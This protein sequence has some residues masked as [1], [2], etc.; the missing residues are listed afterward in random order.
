MDIELV[1]PRKF[2]KNII[3]EKMYKRISIDYPILVRPEVA[4]KLS[5][6]ADKLP[7]PYKLRIDDGYRALY[8][9]NILWQN[10]WNQFQKENPSLNKKELY[11]RTR[12]L[13]FDPKEGIPP[14]STGGA[15]DIGLIDEKDGNDVNLSEPLEKYY[16]EP[17]L[18]SSK[19]NR[20]AQKLRILLHDLMLK[21]G[22]APHPNEFWHFSYGDKRWSEY[23]NG[24]I[25][26]DPI[27]LPKKYYLSLAKRILNRI[28][29]KIWK[30]FKG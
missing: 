15:V 9:Q 30:A 12:D 16:I 20:N 25:L 22:F 11:K 17:Q 13:V 3:P 8:I 24:D 5:K 7:K 1:S 2:G 6:V 4:K 18:Y 19:I 21:E 29:R 14:H 23:Y 26:Y 28:H 27:D 10:R